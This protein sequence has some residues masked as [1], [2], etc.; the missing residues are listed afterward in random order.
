M[1][2]LI[3]VHGQVVS[4]RGTAACELSTFASELSQIVPEPLCPGSLNLVL[5]KPIR[6]AEETA[7]IFDGGRRMIWPAV[8]EGLDV[9]IYRWLETPLHIVEVLSPVFLRERLHLQDGVF[10]DLSVRDEQVDAIT[11][12][13]KLTWASLWLGR[14]GW[15]YSKS[16][17]YS[18]TMYIAAKL[19]GAQQQPMVEGPLQAGLVVAKAIVKRTPVVG[20]L[21]RKLKWKMYGNSGSA[22][23]QF[24][25]IDT[26]GCESDEERQ[27][28]QIR[29]VLNFTKT[30]NSNYSAQQFPAA[31]HTININ[32][33]RV[34]GQ[35]D[36]A[37]RL[38]L[39]PIDF[40]GKTVL[41]LG[42]NQGGMIHQ[43]ADQVRWAVGID[44]D[45]RMIN[46]ATRVKNATGANNTSFYVLDL[47]KG[48]LELISDF[49]PE[50]KVDV[51]FLLSVCMWLDNWKDVI[52]F[53]QTKSRA[54]L[55]ETNG[56]A[57]QQQEQ[58]EYLRT[59]YRGVN[60]LSET[61]EDDPSQKLRKLFYLTAPVLS[62]S[63]PDV[64]A[65][66]REQTA[67]E[68]EVII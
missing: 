67:L 2:S 65:Q 8:L 31:Y 30:S 60:A 47:Q 20:P 58:L 48:P 66:E 3:T 22:A 12:L 57:L 59:K 16:T 63:R 45:S 10:V 35:R 44:Y 43:L 50:E 29:N 5:D 54:M 18:K 13:G 15:S 36:P 37:K 38:A 27:F 14:R 4:G 55:F 53:A 25:R 6:L 40:R 39:V 61:S 26:D 21:A 9:W 17:Y 24:T 49:M 11:P 64:N 23:Y 56:S 28:R 51:C 1:S 52:D 19:G 42:C 33:H 62:V 34:V 46:A 41:D 68:A 32:G 7:F